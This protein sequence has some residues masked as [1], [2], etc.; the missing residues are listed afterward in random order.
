MAIESAKDLN[1]K[2]VKDILKKYFDGEK[3]KFFETEKGKEFIDKYHKFIKSSKF[4]RF[5]A[6]NILTAKEK[7]MCGMSGGRRFARSKKKNKKKKNKTRSRK[8]GALEWIGGFLLM[9]CFAAVGYLMFESGKLSE[10][11]RVENVERTRRNEREEEDELE[12]DHHLAAILPTLQVQRYVED[13]EEEV[14]DVEVERDGREDVVVVP[15]LLRDEEGVEDDVAREE[16]RAKEGV[17]SAGRLAKRVREQ[18]PQ[19]Q[20]PERGREARAEEGEVVLR[21]EREDRQDEEDRKGED[22]RLDDDRALARRRVRRAH[23]ADRVRLDQSPR[24][25]ELGVEGMPVLIGKE[26]DEDPDRR[27][28]PDPDERRCRQNERARGIDKR[29]RRR[30]ARRQREL[31]RQD[32]VHLPDEPEPQ[33]P[34]QGRVRVRAG[35]AQIDR[36]DRRLDIV[37]V[38][39]GHGIAATEP[40]RQIHIRAAFRAEGAIVRIGFALADRAGHDPPPCPS[41]RLASGMRARWRCNS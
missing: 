15:E 30:D 4:S 10:R 36:V 3:D 17:D 6:Q 32:P 2:Q 20:D 33:T 23:R 35:R 8:G 11:A 26:R 14:D 19:D 18:P 29:Q 34:V 22:E 40:A 16:E 24:D 25:E 13:E 9:G 7:K 37:G 31:E 5:T 28:Q 41:S 21:L 1:L 38:I 12:E 39:A 27:D